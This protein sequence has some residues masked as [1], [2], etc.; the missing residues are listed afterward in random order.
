MSDPTPPPDAEE[1]KHR[2]APGEGEPPGARAHEAPAHAAPVPPEHPSVEDTLA[3]MPVIDAPLPEASDR[4][5]ESDEVPPQSEVAR[6]SAWMALGTIVSRV[7]GVGRLLLLAATIG[8][9]L[10]GD[11]FEIANT[12]PNALYI[13]LAGGVFNVVLVPQLVRAMR[14]DDDGG[15][16]YANRILTLGLV[17]VG[18]ATLVLLALVPVVMRIVYPAELFD[19]DL[20]AQRES[21]QLLMYLCMPQVFFYGA[22]V[23]VGQVLNARRRFGPMMW[24]P[25]VNN[26]VAMVSLVVFLVV[27][28]Q[29]AGDGGFTT[30]QAVLLGLGASA[31]ILAQFLVLLPSLRAAG[32]RYSPRFDF[33][34]VG[35]GHTLRLGAWTLGFIAANQVAYVVV[36]RL[37]AT[38]TLTGAQKGEAGAGA[39]VYGIGYLVSQMP[40]GVIT[41]S[42]VTAV[43]PTLSA[44][45]QDR[46]HDRMVLELQRTAR[47]T[48]AIMAPIAVALAC[49]GVPAASVLGALAAPLRA[50]APAIGATMAAFALALLFF[51]IHYTVL[52]GFY[53]DEDTRTP[54]LVQVVI[55]AVNVAAA[56]GFTRGAEPDEFAP[57]LALAFG[58]AYAVGAVLSTTLLSRRLGGGLVDAETRR[59][60][61]KLVV[62]C[63]VAAALMLGATYG[64]A[65]ADVDRDTPTGGLVVVAVAGALGGLGYLAAARLVRLRELSHLVS[66]LLRR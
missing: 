10:N 26:L 34:G 33:R 27:H 21:A 59:F 16:A 12:L 63:G 5:D 1:P 18:V 65:T 31:G 56:I 40:H 62:A 39:A 25:I 66:S 24:A 30:G 51:T 61:L 41:V 9:L 58:V 2:R 17:V 50:G 13:L 55:A 8:T 54:F 57:R 6:A 15:D 7:S 20:A 32:F 53:A 60:L 38:G 14:A 45:A 43:I 22:F 29:V 49:L 48:L 46:R 52:R 4:S 42:L 28:G 47:M 35:L 37:N 11:L 19:A 23:L 3:N 44:L 36:Q 64:L